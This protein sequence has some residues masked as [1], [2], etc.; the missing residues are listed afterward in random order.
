MERGKGLLKITDAE[1]RELTGVTIADIPLKSPSYRLL[2]RVMFFLGLGLLGVGLA[3]VPLIGA[4]AANTALQAALMSLGVSVVAQHNER[5]V[6]PRYVEFAG[7]RS[8]LMAIEKYN[9]V[10]HAADLRMQLEMIGNGAEPSQDCQNAIEAIGLVRQDLVR[11]LRTE[12]IWRENQVFFDQDPMAL[13]G[14]LATMG[15][16]E[17]DDRSSE[18]ARLFDESMQVALVVREEMQQL[19]G[20]KD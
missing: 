13:V 8:L 3:G 2:I 4:S 5:Q 14:D 17:M 6:R 7:L 18:W 19:Q 16:I 1:F 15:T 12:R 11:A 10:A 9:H 20:R